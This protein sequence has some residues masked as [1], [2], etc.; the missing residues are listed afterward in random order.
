MTKVYPEELFEQIVRNVHADIEEY[1]EAKAAT[2]I[3]IKMSDEG[4]QY[5]T[6]N[7]NG[8]IYKL[9]SSKKSIKTIK[10]NEY[11]LLAVLTAGW[12]APN[13]EDDEYNNIPPSEHPDRKRVRM[14]LVGNTAI[15]Y[16]S[17]LSIDGQDED[18]FDYMTARGTLQEAFTEF[19]EN[20]RSND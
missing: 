20:W 5:E 9:L 3:G 16:G 14:T 15:Q 11:N 13:N 8:D 2:L 4:V 12:A 18:M 7:S 19:M 10:L 6:I 17:V 1:R